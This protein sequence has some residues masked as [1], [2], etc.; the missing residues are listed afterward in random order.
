MQVPTVLGPRPVTKTHRVSAGAISLRQR[1]EDDDLRQALN[2]AQ[3]LASL[4]WGV[5]A[6]GHSCP[7]VPASGQL[8]ANS[9]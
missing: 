4:P 7:F 2:L 1:S 9:R 3:Q 8:K 6:V 5:D